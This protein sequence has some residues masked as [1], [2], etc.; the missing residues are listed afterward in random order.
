M[1]VGI[2]GYG[3]VGKHQQSLFT[4]AVIYDKFQNIGC[5]TEINECDCVF[6]CVP[7][8]ANIDGSCD[9]S[10]VEEV[11][12]WV[13]SPLIIIRSTVSIGFTDIMSEKYGKQIVFQ[14]EYYGETV[15]HPFA[16]NFNSKWLVLG[17]SQHCIDLAIE[18]YQQTLNASVDIYQLPAKEAEFVKYMENAFL[19][20]K[21][22]FCNEMYDLAKKFDLSYNQIRE[23]WT[24]DPR[25]GKSHSFVYSRNRGFGGKCLPKD[26]SSLIHQANRLESDI[27]LLESVLK[28]N[29]L[30]SN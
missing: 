9:T 28:K 12:G 24:A 15:D 23:A 2:V 13:N 7:T 19:A 16:K 1:K 27:T 21:V 8:P 30:Y 26:L 29:K 5:K 17:G 25:I 22:I 20:T 3:H 10:A 6:I 18:V 14:P 11:I 4:N